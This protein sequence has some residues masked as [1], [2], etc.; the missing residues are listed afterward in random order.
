MLYLVNMTATRRIA[1]FYTILTMTKWFLFS[2]T[3]HF[4]LCHFLLSLYLMLSFL[5]LLPNSFFLSTST[6]IFQYRYALFN[7]SLL[8]NW[9]LSTKL[10][11]V[12]EKIFFF[13]FRRRVCTRTLPSS[14]SHHHRGRQIRWRKHVYFLII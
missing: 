5:L 11:L 7:S 4:L 10:F 1:I 14:V 9:T 6:I 13:L 8:L 12:L 2:E 3:P